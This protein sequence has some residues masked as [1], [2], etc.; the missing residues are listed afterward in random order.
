MNN[1]CYFQ[2]PKFKLEYE[3]KIVKVITIDRSLGAL[4]CEALF[5]TVDEEIEMIGLELLKVAQ[6]GGELV[7][8]ENNVCSQVDAMKKGGGMC[9][10]PKP[11]LH[12]AKPTNDSARTFII[13]N[14]CGYYNQWF[15]CD[16][17]V[18]TSY[19]HT[20]H[21]FCFEA[22]LKDSIKCCVCK[23]KLHP[24]WWVS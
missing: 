4:Q 21:P 22:M 1:D 5:R 16:D 11:I 13:I 20:F 9:L 17:I 19:R 10:W 14:A 23:Q 3:L 7:K 18:V 12:L 2:Q 15:H 6:E 8:E 24:H